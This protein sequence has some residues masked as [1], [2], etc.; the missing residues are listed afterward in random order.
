MDSFVQRPS[1]AVGFFFVHPCA[2]QPYV[3]GC[4]EVVEHLVTGVRQSLD[5]RV[6]VRSNATGALAWAW[7]SVKWGGLSAEE[8]ALGELRALSKLSATWH[9]HALAPPRAAHARATSHSTC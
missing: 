7:V 6:Q 3:T 2:L 5:L 9:E 8:C 1:G 4:P